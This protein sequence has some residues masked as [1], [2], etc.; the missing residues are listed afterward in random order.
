MTSCVVACI[1]S[2]LLPRLVHILTCNNSHVVC[3]VQ[4]GVLFPLREGSGDGG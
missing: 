1:S 4:G 3:V 2:L